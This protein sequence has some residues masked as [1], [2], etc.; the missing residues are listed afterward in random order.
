MV[1]KILNDN[2]SLAVTKSSPF[3]QFKMLQSDCGYGDL[4]DI[5][6]PRGLRQGVQDGVL[7]DP[8][9]AAIVLG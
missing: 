9:K 8:M 1:R 2:E 4:D 7:P 6:I 3:V 5:L